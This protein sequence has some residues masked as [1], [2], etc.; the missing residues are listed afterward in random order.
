MNAALKQEWLA[1]LRS[2]EYAQGKHAL[3][4]TKPGGAVTYCCLGV[5]CD[6]LVKRGEGTWER[7]EADPRQLFFTD[8]ITNDGSPHYVPAGTGDRINLAYTKTRDLAYLNDRN[9]SF[10]EI[11]QHI[12]ARIPADEAQS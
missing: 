9:H 10:N 1:A 7:S 6:L 3:A 4:M 11:A 5:L 8:T 12:E 2:G